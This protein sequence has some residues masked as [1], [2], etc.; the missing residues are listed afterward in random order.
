MW[1]LA[2]I[3]FEARFRPENQIYRV[4]QRMR[5]CGVLVA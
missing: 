1:A 5:N 2:H 4:N 3:Y